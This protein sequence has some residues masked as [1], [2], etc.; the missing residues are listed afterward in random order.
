MACYTSEQVDLY[1]KHINLASL[2]GNWHVRQMDDLKAFSQLALI[3]S[4][5]LSRVPFDSVALHY[6]PTRLLS[7][8]PEDLF[9][10]VVMNSRGGYCMEVNA[11]FG[12]V[13]RSMGYDVISVGGRVKHKEW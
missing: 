7:L 9:Q 3:Q 1:L 11:L 6:S 2:A 5:H 4:H 8:H 10:K 12:N 13:L